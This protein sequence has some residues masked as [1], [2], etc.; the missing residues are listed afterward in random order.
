M[1]PM[2][3]IKTRLDV[4]TIPI[5]IWRKGKIRRTWPEPLA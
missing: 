5:G 1:L 4:M 3:T 2:Q